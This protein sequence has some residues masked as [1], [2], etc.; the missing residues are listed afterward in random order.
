MGVSE[1]LDV[2]YFGVI[3]MTFKIIFLRDMEPTMERGEAPTT[4]GPARE[5]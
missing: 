3:L 2:A 4:T 1:I 5:G